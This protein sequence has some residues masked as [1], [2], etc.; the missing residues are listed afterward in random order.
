MTPERYKRVKDIFL[1]ACDRPR[2]EQAGY[3][4]TECGQDEEIR[5]EVEALLK[6]HSR[7]TQV[8]PS[9]PEGPLG[10]M[11]AILSRANI[12]LENPREV[13]AA[14]LEGDVK[15]GGEQRNYLDESTTGSQDT[16]SGIVDPGRFPAGTVAAGRYRI[17][18]LLGRGGMGEV[19]RA[20]DITLNQSVALKFLPS[21]F[22]SDPKWLER[23]RNEVRLARQVTHPNVCRVFDI[24]EYQGEQFISMEYIDGENLASTLRRI[25]RVPHDKAM[26]IARQLCAGLA[27][28]HDR[29][30]LHRDLKPANVM[31]DGRGSVRIT[32]FGLAAPADQLR[33]EA[34]RAGTPAYM[35][36]E[37]LAGK[38]VTV[39]SDIYSLGLVLYEM[40]TGRRAF[41]AESLREYQ[42]LHSS[43]DPTP[44]SEL[45]DDID[46]IVERVILKCLE[47]DPKNRPASAMAVSAAL[48]GGNPLREIL[49]AGETPSP[50]VVAA[51]GE[52]RGM[53]RPRTAMALIA[54]AI[55]CIGLFVAMAPKLFV[56]QRAI[57][58]KPPAVLTDKAQSIL[59][60]LGYT[61]KPRDSAGAF[62]ANPAYY[63]W[64]ESNQNA[65]N[66]LDLLGQSRPGL[67]YYWYRQSPELLI[68]Q[69]QDGMVVEH[70]PAPILP[71]M[72][73][74]QLDPKGRLIGLEVQPADLP[75]RAKGTAPAT[76]AEKTV[77]W[78]PL[79]TAAEIDKEMER[80]KPVPPRGAPPVYADERAAWEGSFSD[81]TGD[82]VRV[83]AAAYQG[84]PVYFSVIGSW[85][86][87]NL[88]EERA[89][90]LSQGQSN[91]VVQTLVLGALLVGGC[92]LA[93]KNYTSGRGDRMGAMRIAF[94][95]LVLGL[96]V[97]VLRAHHVAD[98]VFE[99][100]LFHRGLGPNLYLVCIVWIFY[101]ALEPYVRRVWPETVIS[102]N[103]LLA[104]K[105]LDPVVGRDV[106][107]GSAVGALS[108]LLTLGEYAIP[109]WLHGPSPLPSITSMT[110]MLNSTGS[111]AP[112]FTNAITSLYLGL[113]ALLFLVLM[114]M[115]SNRQWVAGVAFIVV[116]AAATARYSVMS[117]WRLV[118]EDLLSW[119]FQGVLALLLLSLLT[120]HGLVAVIF[121]LLVRGLLTDFPVTW[122]FSAWYSS[123]SVIAIVSVF[124]MLGVGV[125]SALGR[126]LRVEGRPEL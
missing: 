96:T 118:P 75:I 74:V 58:N 36:P 119:S 122:D 4:H 8:M 108:M 53:I 85:Q 66:R 103:R 98:P 105:W 39:R 86:E 61:G 94:A 14:H 79:L 13:A 34:M 5:R 6:E 20:D 120:Q 62:A 7:E 88:S 110:L 92:A 80:F 47:K 102:W 24:G 104:G 35:S 97:W 29:G 95:F 1:A 28:A 69:R 3:I 107:A 11:S 82:T 124:V 59:Q 81:A 42:R 37:Q 18:E 48:P 22:G 117:S 19:Y 57:S 112:L 71:G 44:P 116:F 67:I 9:E 125:Y 111:L 123:T 27:A 90:V 40:F 54:T 15:P 56:V 100:V 72:A 93:W 76:E 60:S 65:R 10:S 41:R 73:T 17:I 99:F 31:I 33:A 101:I 50:E 87:E 49:A 25:G 21:L 126:P 83:E 106:L 12:D 89:M 109:K 64:V 30:V 52:A 55:V 113:L 77:D 121:C 26:Q 68:P 51:A 45:L 114:R 70:D 32:D 2:G 46:P 115:V 38:P 78:S 23:F 91:L 16:S 84:K 63:V 43:E